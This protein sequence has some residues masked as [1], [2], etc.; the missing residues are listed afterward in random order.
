MKNAKKIVLL[1]S[2]I[3]IIF[4]L[5]GC[6]KKT[7]N[8]DKY[9]TITATGYDT[10]GSASYEF[11]YDSFEADYSGKIKI[12]GNN[13]DLKAI[14]LLTGSSTE[15]LLISACVKPQLD[16]NSNLCNGDTVTLK[17][18]CNYTVAEE[19]FNVNLECSDIN[20][21][22]SDLDELGSFNPFDYVSVEFS[23]ISPNGTATIVPDDN[24]PE[25]K[26]FRFT[27]DKSRDIANGDTITVT[28]TFSGTPVAFAEEFGCAV[29]ETEKTYTCESISYY[30]SDASEIPQDTMDKMIA[31][32]L[33]EFNAN[34]VS[35]WDKPENLND[36]QYVGNYLVTLKDGMKATPNNTIYLIYK[37]NATNVKPAEEVEYYYYV[38]FNDVLILEDGTGSVNLANAIIPSKYSS[39]S[40][41]MVGKYTYVGYKDLDSFV[42]HCIV[43][44]IDKYNYASTIE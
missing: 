12:S 18:N 38:A 39:Q 9:M 32:G 24:Q 4:T 30:V 36:V 5:S 14:G 41:F 3:T 31:Q 35:R 21:T 44:A 42:N 6:G 20:Y 26:Y 25:M 43:P 13:E 33:D 27:A 16:K 10:M 11:D 17:W 34:E 37:V 1:V 28:A 40:R 15:E 2:M 29:S 23:G 8:L 7:I 22:V 19:Y